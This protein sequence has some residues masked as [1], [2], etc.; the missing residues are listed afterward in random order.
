VM[1]QQEVI[2]EFMRD[3]G[4]D[5]HMRR[6]RAA[7]RTQATQMIDAVTRYFPP[8][9]KLS[10]PQGGYMLWIELPRQ[11]DSRKVFELARNEHIGIAPGATFSCS[12]RFD[13]FIRIHYGEPWSTRLDANLKRL[14]EIV[15]ELAAQG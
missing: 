9:C 15:A 10:R 8:G 7:I 11:V 14:G 13:H 3:G 2:A 6:L 1:L 12:R 4:Y 5:H